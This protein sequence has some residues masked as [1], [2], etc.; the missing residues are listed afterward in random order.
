MI[1]ISQGA[2]EPARRAGKSSP[3]T[4]AHASSDN[5]GGAGPAILSTA[6]A[7]ALT[8]SAA[9]STGDAMAAPE[10]ASIFAPASDVAAA[11]PPPAAMDQAPPAASES[12]SGPALAAATAAA[13]MLP[14]D[15]DGAAA[16]LALPPDQQH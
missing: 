8:M 9:T 3:D 15:G 1:T 5:A 7:E 13:A 14:A 12:G 11:D 16:A 2:T 4:A 10:V 6:D